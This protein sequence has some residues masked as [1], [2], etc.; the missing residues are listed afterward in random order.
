MEKI[1]PFKNTWYDWSYNC[2]PGP[3]T[4]ILGGSKD[5]ILSL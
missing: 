2:I 3:I 5:K 4:N 1:R